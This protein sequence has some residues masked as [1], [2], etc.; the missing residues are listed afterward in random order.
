MVDLDIDTPTSWRVLFTR[1]AV[2]NGILFTMEMILRSSN[3]VVFREH[4][5]LFALLS[6]PVPSFF[7]GM[8]QTVDLATPNS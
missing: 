4:P 8:Y 5:G 3:T 7:L 2:V 6:S 1:L